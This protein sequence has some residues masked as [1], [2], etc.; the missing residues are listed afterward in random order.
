MWSKTA[1]RT[2][3]VVVTTCSAGAALVS[4]LSYAQSHGLILPGATPPA[5]ETP[6][7]YAAGAPAP[8][9]AWIGVTP[10][11]DTATSIGD[12]LHFTAR[13]ADSRGG[14]VVGAPIAWSS[15]SAAVATVSAD[16]AVIARSPGVATIYAAAGARVARARV[17]VRPRVVGARI[18]GDS[19]TRV[20][21][22]ERRRLREQGVD[23]RGHAVERRTVV[24]R[25]ADS[26]VAR[27]DSTG[28]ALGL[29]PGHT[30]VTAVVDGISTQTDVEVVELPGAVT[31]VGGETQHASAGRALPRPIEVEVLSASGRPVA[32]VAV[33][34][35]ADGDGGH[36]EPAS[37]TTDARGRART[38]W[39]LGDAPGRQQL[40]VLVDG[41][42]TPAVARAESEPVATNVKT[43]PL[44]E[45]A[46][47]RVGEAVEEEV[48]LRLTDSLGRALP[49]VPVVW[50]A[51]DGGRIE[52]S[53]PRTDSLGQ[54]RIQWT[55][56]PKAGVQHAVAS[57]GDGRAVPRATIGAVAVPGPVAAL[58]VAGGG[59]Q[60][61][62]V[63]AALPRPVLLR[64]VDKGGNAIPGLPVTLVPAHG[65]VADSAP[66]TDSLGAVRVAWTL[67]R[68]AG[69]QRL[70]ARVAG[71]AAP[72]AVTVRARPLAPANV[73]F[74]DSAPDGP[75]GRTLP[76]A[77]AV[78]VTDAYGNP[79]PDALVQF[80]AESG[81]SVSSA[82]VMTDADGR[83]ATRWRLG[84]KE[85]EQRLTASARGSEAR[86]TLAVR[87][88]RA[89]PAAAPV[90]AAT[91]PT[92]KPAPSS[93]TK[94]KP[95][96]HS[97]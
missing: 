22:G 4:I 86:A 28:D 97:R 58:V 35:G 94:P 72:L 38:R 93:T 48:G 52:A 55:L 15:D 66:V 54:A 70:M 49:D 19:V 51:R 73:A 25:V 64:A 32:G 16:G 7:R 74:P 23:A 81:G 56:G 69:E 14:T 31:V 53:G 41:L 11:A 84:A 78:T 59:S 63:G 62:S 5:G 29:A 75:P 18:V 67:G 90:A 79:V 6:L 27:V 33:R 92:P 34:F 46:T 20:A 37:A 47:G 39:T 1:V 13:V 40:S 44:S 50:T 96:R 42:A 43:Y 61:A 60:S 3:K 83:A 21:V 87:A 45:M 77:V 26:S 80:R 24:W 65:T 9:V 57:I 30:T 89:E 68:A 17:V 12:T 82:R 95:G 85:G 76:A 88:V 71:V 2:S 8:D 36:A 91:K 10:A